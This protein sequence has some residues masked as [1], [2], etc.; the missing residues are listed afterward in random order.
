MSEQPSAACDRCGHADHG[1]EPC[2]HLMPG[3]GLGRCVCP[4]PRHAVVMPENP[5]NRHERYS[6]RCGVPLGDTMKVALPA[7]R[8]HQEADCGETIRLSKLTWLHTLSGSNLC[9]SRTVA[10]PDD[11]DHSE[12]T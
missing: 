2:D 10:Q 8:Q 12:E 11:N 6:C 3:W 4:G 7:F 5:D 1:T 9:P